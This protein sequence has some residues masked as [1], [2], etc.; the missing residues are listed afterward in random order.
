MYN[1]F[2]TIKRE[3]ILPEED[4]EMIKCRW[5]PCKTF[6]GYQFHKHE[7]VQS[8]KVN[9]SSY[10]NSLPMTLSGSK[11]SVVLEMAIPSLIL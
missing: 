5:T 8:I 3:Y 4:I 11:I 2:D 9:K 7:R 1:Y 10:Q 6:Q